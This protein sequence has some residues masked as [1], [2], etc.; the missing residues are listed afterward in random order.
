MTN[1]D[2]ILYQEVQYF[3]QLWFC[4]LI[5]II[6]GFAIFAMVQQLIIGKP[7]GENP[8]PDTVMIAIGVLIGFG[9][10]IFLFTMRLITEVRSDGLYFR[11]F[12]FHFSFHK[13]AFWDMRNYEVRTYRAIKDYGGWGIRYGKEGKAYNVSGNKGVQLE[14]SNGEKILIGSQRAEELASAIASASKK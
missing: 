10:P 9:L 7:F 1:N 3:R 6:A 5:I 12:P 8:A 11:L 2:N 4:I 14:L 13:I